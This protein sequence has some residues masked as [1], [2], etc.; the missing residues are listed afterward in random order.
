M[1][2]L[3][4]FDDGLRARIFQ[5]NDVRVLSEFL[6]AMEK[7][8]MYICGDP[9]GCRYCFFRPP[10]YQ[11]NDFQYCIIG[12]WQEKF[13]KEDDIG[14]I[15]KQLNI[16]SHLQSEVRLYLGAVPQ[17]NSP[18][19]WERM[20]F[21]G[22]S[23]LYGG[24]VT[25]QIS[26]HE[27]ALDGPS[28]DYS[29]RLDAALTKRLINGRYDTEAALLEAVSAGNADK[30]LRCI[31]GFKY[32]E[33]N[34]WSEDELRNGKN[35]VIVMDTLL[36]KAVEKDYIHPVHIDTT[37]AFFA[38]R[39]ENAA[40][41]CELRRIVELMI[42]R[43]CALVEKFSLRGYSS[44]IRNIINTVDFNLQEPLS[45]SSLAKQ[46]NVNRSNLSAQFKR[47]KGI[48]LIKYINTKRM[49]RAAY[50]FR[51]SGD[52][53]QKVAEQCGFLNTNYFSRLFKQ[54]YGLS[55]QGFLKESGRL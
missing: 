52:Y 21:A 18:H 47:E 4:N 15:F 53:I 28:I 7:E 20:L 36:R 24:D 17:I 34:L 39:I 14:T 25:V 10:L 3:E 1:I 16:P 54:Y 27:K 6:R 44:L 42:R 33:K 41:Q 45:V 30:A 9:Y 2:G 5:E 50:L 26:R 29:P 38:R 40:S 13:P 31:V 22:I 23:Y 11:E 46:F 51:N 48:S 37:S 55:P 12:P 8:V 35:Y 19:S 43:Y 32:S 49:E